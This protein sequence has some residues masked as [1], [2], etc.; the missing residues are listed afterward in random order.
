MS[1]DKSQ[2]ETQTLNET[3]TAPLNE[4]TLP[5]PAT[6]I[7]RVLDARY[8]IESELG[9]GGVGVVYL[10]HDLKLHNRRVVVKALL[11]E[12]LDNAWVVQK[13]QQEKEALARVDHPGVVG[14]L[15]TGELPDGKPY[16]VMQ[17]VDGVTL[18]SMIKPEGISLDHAGEI[19]KQIG[20][21]L[22]A[23]H[24][25][26]IF[27]RDLK[28]ENIML[29]SFADGEEQVKIIDF[30]IAKLKDSTVA[31]S[32]A[33]GA[34]AGT[35]AYMAPEQLSGR[36]ISA[37]TD[38]YAFG[39]IA[40]EILTGRKPFNPETGFELLEMQR[41]GLRVNVSDLRPAV[42]GEASDL[43]GR[44][45]KFEPGARFKS[46]REFGDTLARVLSDEVTSKQPEDRLPEIAA[47]QLATQA[48]P[49]TRRTADVA[50][51]TMAGRFEPAKVD[52]LNQPARAPAM[53]VDEPQ[54]RPGAKIA[55]GLIA[56]VVIGA[57]AAILIWKRDGIFGASS[58]ERSL[59]YSLTVQKM[60][61]GKPYQSEFQSSGQEIFENGWKFRMN[62]TSPQDGYLYLLD[63][64]PASGD[65]I[66]YDVLFPEP[67]T[68]GGSARATANQKLQTA[69]MRFDDNQGTEK[70]W[71]VWA[72]APVKELE[73]VTGA[74]NDRDIGQIKDTAKARAVYD[75]LKQH[76]SPKPELT[77][78][79][80]QDQSIVKARTDVLVSLIELKHH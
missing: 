25:K 5:S 39:T 29:Q 31:P 51:K 52:T 43:V 3:S 74:V 56:L 18:R 67:K 45:L 28:P 54:G 60:R 64:G 12:S 75:F 22:S 76:S 44:A 36:A 40:Y 34:T 55:F 61:D 9:R 63:E 10:A 80:G 68:N 48:T 42:S 11:D 79:S 7:G 58:P 71:M 49:E 14:V 53:G 23:A 37:A 13:F 27:H 59:A 70:F 66:S 1:L 17:F 35:V 2:A 20:R 73:A 24:D 8:L 4:T 69:W 77:K 57:L 15:D 41:R 26:G 19:I 32:T 30:G 21:S 50:Q 78:D 38:V 33:T 46:A 6:L 72:A 16:I 62:L 65:A 47:T